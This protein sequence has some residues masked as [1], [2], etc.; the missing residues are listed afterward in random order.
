VDKGFLC[1]VLVAVSRS[2]A[3]R[4]GTK[5]IAGARA[6]SRDGEEEEI[7]PRSRMADQRRIEN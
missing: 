1:P 3:P 5:T 4:R 7:E 2:C 6:G